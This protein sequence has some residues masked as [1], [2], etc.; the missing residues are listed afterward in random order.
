MRGAHGWVGGQGRQILVDAGQ[1]AKGLPVGLS[2]VVEL[3]QD[4]VGPLGRPTAG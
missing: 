2:F 1:E 4:V 3:E